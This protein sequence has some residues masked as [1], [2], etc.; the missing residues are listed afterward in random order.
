[1]IAHVNL[2]LKITENSGLTADGIT[3]ISN[4][5]HVSCNV[6]D[7]TEIETVVGLII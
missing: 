5:S 2:L 7:T 6:K 4:W 1:M 3:M